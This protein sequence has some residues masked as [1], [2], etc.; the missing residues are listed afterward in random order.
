[1]WFSD[2][3]SELSV[4]R[5]NHDDGEGRLFDDGED[6]SDVDFDMEDD[7][8]GEWGLDDSEIDSDDD[9]DDDDVGWDGDQAGEERESW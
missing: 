9:S 7:D 6:S 2:R 8:A 5:R 1:M 4:R 3:D